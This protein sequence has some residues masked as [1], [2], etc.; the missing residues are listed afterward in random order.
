MLL[1]KTE[2]LCAHQERDLLYYTFP[3]LD[4]L[5]CVRHGFSTRLGGVSE[6]IFASMN[7]SFTRGD[8]P[9]AVRENFDRFCAAIGVDAD[10]VVISAQTHTANV[11][12]VTAEDCGRGVTR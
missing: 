12:I 2:A 10:H 5:G 4:D 8:D 9:V 6:G 1:P 11:K 7:L 3:A